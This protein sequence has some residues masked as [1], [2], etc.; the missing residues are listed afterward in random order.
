MKMLGRGLDEEHELVLVDKGR[1]LVVVDKGRELVVVDKGRELVVD[2]RREL[3]VVDKTTEDNERTTEDGLVGDLE[4][5]TTVDGGEFLGA[6][7]AGGGAG[8]GVA[9][10]VAA[11]AGAE[12]RVDI[13]GVRRKR[14]RWREGEQRNG[15]ARCA[16]F[17][18]K[19]VKHEG[20][21]F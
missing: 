13:V 17:I 8:F 10:L 14:E 1:E 12:T 19:D 7:E 3:V 4:A 16:T 11:G 2:N 9:G 20:E 21:W 18:S 5:T 6:L 15:K